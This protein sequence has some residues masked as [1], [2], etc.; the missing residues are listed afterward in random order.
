MTPAARLTSTGLAWRCLTSRD[1]LRFCL[2]FSNLAWSCL[3]SSELSWPCFTLSYLAWPS[4][5]PPDLIWPHLHM[6]DHAWPR[7]TSPELIWSR[8]TSSDPPLTSSDLFWPCFSELQYVCILSFNDLNFFFKVKLKTCVTCRIL[9]WTIEKNLILE[10]FCK[11]TK[12]SP[13]SEKKNPHLFLCHCPFKGMC[14]SLKKWLDSP[15]Y[16]TAGRSTQ[17]SSILRGDWL[18]AVWYCT[19]LIKKKLGEI[20]KQD[21]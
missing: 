2:T 13:F 8:L 3:T 11:H 16:D 7:L 19:K 17:R 6:P 1:L 18:S 15:Q 4:L 5:T 14:K 10:P 12:F 20:F 21:M 9:V